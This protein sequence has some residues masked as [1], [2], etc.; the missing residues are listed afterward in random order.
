M[1]SI[2]IMERRNVK[3]EKE[4]L[5]MA[6]AIDLLE[7]Q[8]KLLEQ[9]ITRK[10][11][12]FK[13]IENKHVKEF[14]E[15]LDDLKEKEAFIELSRKK[16]ND[17]GKEIKELK[18]KI[19]ETEDAKDE[20]EKLNEKQKKMLKEIVEKNYK[21][22]KDA[23]EL[24]K[25][26]ENLVNEKEE[27]GRKYKEME[28]DIVI[29]EK[30]VK[31][32]EKLNGEKELLIIDAKCE[33]EELIARL[34]DINEENDA[35]KAK[36]D[37]FNSHENKESEFTSSSLEEELSCLSLEKEILPMFNCKNCEQSFSS[38]KNLRKHTVNVHM[39]EEKIKL[40]RIE[41]KVSEQT[42]KLATDLNKLI[43]KECSENRSPCVCR[44]FCNINHLKHNWN[45]PAST[46]IL[47]KFASLKIFARP[48][49]GSERS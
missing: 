26:E 4:N 20:L 27:L 33:H 45:K 13:E 31:N 25:N 38:R 6:R 46:N 29:L 9:T 8:A 32:I 24:K 2:S 22:E 14:N 42:A 39:A 11:K 3:L 47:K 28:I 15:L 1:D 17:L 48:S 5:Q 7:T 30:Q 41:D 49:G 23:L 10:D 43:S 18:I 16:R 12:Q 37:K 34:E 36:L 44:H 21:Y 40:L 35:L 19:K